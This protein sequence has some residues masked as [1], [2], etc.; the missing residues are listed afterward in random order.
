MLK[1][2][3]MGYLSPPPPPSPF[4]LGGFYSLDQ[5]LN[6]HAFSFLR[7]WL[8]TNLSSGSAPSLTPT[9]TPTSEAQGQIPMSPSNER[10]S[11]SRTTPSYSFTSSL[12][13]PLPSAIAQTITG[14]LT[15][16]LISPSRTRQ[17]LKDAAVQY[18]LRVID[19][20]ERSEQLA[21]HNSI[22]VSL[23]LCPQ[24]GILPH[25]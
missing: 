18:C 13:S 11:T 8:L 10:R 23:S 15:A 5:L 16:S 19:Q 2:V 25:T 14:S 21:R 17:G 12:P 24:T 9:P 6:I 7:R 4:P 1:H 20:C 3:S 22:S